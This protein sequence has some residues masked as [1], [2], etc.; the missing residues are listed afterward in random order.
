M[1][2]STNNNKFLSVL[3][4]AVFIAIFVPTTEAAGSRGSVRH[5]RSDEKED[6]RMLKSSKA[7][8]KDKAG[9]NKDPKVG[10]TSR[11]LI[12]SHFVVWR[13]MRDTAWQ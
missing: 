10:L 5:R 11:A 2:I 3:V 13:Y 7:G 4:M 1:N 9:N 8:N 12:T 6:N